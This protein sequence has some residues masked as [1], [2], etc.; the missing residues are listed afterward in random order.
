MKNKKLFGIIG[1][2]LIIFGMLGTIPFLQNRQY[3]GLIITG[4]VVILGV[5]LVASSLNN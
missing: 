1:V 2:I 3:V 4:V 5:I